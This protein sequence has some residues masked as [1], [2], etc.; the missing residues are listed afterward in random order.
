MF[1]RGLNLSNIWYGHS[2]S[3][4]WMQ[5]ELPT[6]FDGVSYEKSGWCYVEAAMSAAIKVGL[7]RLDLSQRTGVA[8]ATCYSTTGV[9]MACLDRVCAKQRLP[10]PTPEQVDHNLQIVKVFTNRADIDAVSTLYQTYFNDVTR[11]LKHLDVSRLGWGWKEVES[12]CSDFIPCCASLMSINLS[13]NELCSETA[14]HIAKVICVSASLANINLRRNELGDEGTKHI[15]E[16]IAV[17]A[18][19]TYLW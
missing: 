7:N 4:C 3:T 13:Q 8:M 16:G 2:Q 18:S 19:L 11:D 10:P 1:K 15:A 17:S 12:L 6:S 9:A 5:S 14:K